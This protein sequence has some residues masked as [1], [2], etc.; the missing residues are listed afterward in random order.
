MEKEKK[1]KK[2][3][4]KSTEVLKQY[5]RGKLWWMAIIFT[6]LAALST[7]YNTGTY[8]LFFK[9]IEW[10]KM[11]YLI[12]FVVLFIAGYV[13]LFWLDKARIF[14]TNKY[15]ANVL[16]E[17]KQTCIED[18]IVKGK[19]SAEV[20]SFLDNDL[21]LLM[22]GYFA[23]IFQIVSKVSIV[24]FTLSL[25][26]TS[27]WI[28]ALVYLVLG[29]LPLQLTGILAGRV[30]R[31]T[32][33]YGESVK[34]TT[35]LVK[36]VVRNK[37]T[38]SNYGAVGFALKRMKERLFASESSLAE[39][40]NAMAYANTLMN[41]V[42]MVAN[43]V[44]I[45]IGIFMGIKGMLNISDFVAV[46]YSSGWI[47]GSLGALAG[48]ISEMKSTQPICDKIAAFEKW[49]GDENRKREEINTV[50]FDQVDFSYVPEKPILRDLSFKAGKGEKVLIQGSSGSGKSTILKLINRELKPDGGSVFLNGKDTVVPKAG[51]VSQDPA[52]FSDTIRYNLTLGN[53]FDED[54][55][56]NAVERAGLHDF[57]EE[58]GLDYVIEEEGGNLSGGQKQRIEI[59][60]ALLYDCSMLLIDEGTSA[61]DAKTAEKVHDTVMNLGKTVVEV[62]H[63]IPDDVKEKFDHILEL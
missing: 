22:D 31:K 21:K 35:D 51:Y 13:I 39:R 2:K 5:R 38:L 29:F 36:D 43:I 18:A 23:N 17:I 25:T 9:L 40:N 52:M 37:G 61:L 47:V 45:S 30:G 50:E 59:A 19:D 57:V 3:K 63:Y 16:T 27:N 20:I 28:F 7:P 62:A 15:Q 10:G 44:P 41:I 46:Q 58:N 14:A 60:R 1:T 55:I 54:R 24:V 34:E 53:E 11:E 42:Y 12:P 6:I 8:A 4:S 26:L 33:E 56:M 48:L 32:S 49:E